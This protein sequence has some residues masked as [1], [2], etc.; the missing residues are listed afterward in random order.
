MF[1]TIG[2]VYAGKRQRYL[3]LAELPFDPRVDALGVMA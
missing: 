2:V 3:R 1:A